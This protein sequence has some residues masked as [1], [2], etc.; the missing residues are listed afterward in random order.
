LQPE[1]DKEVHRDVLYGL[2]WPA[3]LAGVGVLFSTIASALSLYL[4]PNV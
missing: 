4:P 2:L 1:S 3:V